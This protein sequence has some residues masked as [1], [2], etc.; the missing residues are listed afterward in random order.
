MNNN[1]KDRRKASNKKLGEVKMAN[2]NLS[3]KGNLNYHMVDLSTIK[4]GILSLY[5]EDFSKSFYLR[6]IA[7]VLKKSHVS[8][9]PHLKELV[10]GKILI[11]KKVGRNRMY[12][13][14][15]DNYFVCDY[16]IV[17]E[18]LKSISFLKSNSLLRKFYFEFDDYNLDVILF[19]SFARGNFNSESDVDI[20]ILG[21]LSSSKKKRIKD[22]GKSYSRDFHVVNFS[23]GDFYSSKE[24]PFVKEILKNHIVLSGADK[25]VKKRWDKWK[26]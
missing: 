22:F 13:L 16:L 5:L 14:N 17:V 10:E 4:V 8:L 7:R 12:S 11:A 21:N 2:K 1:L 23:V 19:G 9:I 3:K 20:L 15:F 25:F 18:K 24:N 26:I 6:E